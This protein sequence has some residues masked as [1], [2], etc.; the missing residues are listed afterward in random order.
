MYKFINKEN[1]TEKTQPSLIQSTIRNTLVLF[2]AW[3]DETFSQR[4]W[5]SSVAKLNLLTDLQSLNNPS[6]RLWRDATLKVLQLA[7]Y[8]VGFYKA[9]VEQHT[10]FLLGF[11]MPFS[12]SA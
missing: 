9:W 2:K 10:L 6:P 11:L 4:I 1:N 5:Q 8:Q 12:K 3:C 7:G